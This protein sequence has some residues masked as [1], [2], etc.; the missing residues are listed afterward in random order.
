M[1]GRGNPPLF[2]S[3]APPPVGQRLIVKS[4]NRIGCSRMLRFAR[5][6]D[7][8]FEEIKN[9]FHNKVSTRISRAPVLWVRG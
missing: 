6:S 2:I 4:N 5:M 7:S 8:E 9:A 1:S 3:I